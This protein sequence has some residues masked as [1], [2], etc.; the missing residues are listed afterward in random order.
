MKDPLFRLSAQFGAAGPGERASA[1]PGLP[2]AAA[3]PSRFVARRVDH[4]EDAADITQQTLLL[5]CA[6]FQKGD[7][8]IDNLSRWLRTIAHHLIVDHYRAR[9]RARLTEVGNGWVDPEPAL[10][11]RADMPLAIAEC[12]QQLN[13][14]LDRVTR[15]VWLE[16]QVAVLM[17]DVYGYAD[18]HSA[19]QLRMT[20]PSFKML[21]HQARAS[22]REVTERAQSSGT[23]TPSA[24]GEIVNDTGRG[25]RIVLPVVALAWSGQR[26]PNLG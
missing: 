24:F 2:T 13:M 3:E 1:V 26:G 9:N 20:L 12:R 25:L 18:K 7:G 4:P 23:G 6:E 11:T 10:Q 19:A 21:L 22:L 17:S 8:R 5:A 14:F 16:H 15:L